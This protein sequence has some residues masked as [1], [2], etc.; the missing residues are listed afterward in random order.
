MKLSYEFRRRCEM[1]STNQRQLLKLAP[2]DPLQGEV[3][4]ER[5]GVMLCEPS[6]MPGVTAE[7]A[8]DLANRTDW[9]G[10]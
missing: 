6:N 9:D 7:E 8:A 1:I 3:L 2:H 4:A 10:V 5:H